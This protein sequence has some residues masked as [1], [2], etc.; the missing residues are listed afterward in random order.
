MTATQPQPQAEMLC[1]GA[2]GHAECPR[3]RRFLEGCL[4]PPSYQ[5]KE[6]VFLP[7]T[8]RIVAGVCGMFVRA[9]DRR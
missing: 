7:D 1:T 2:A 6:R 4:P 3:C 9:E 5:R 8:P